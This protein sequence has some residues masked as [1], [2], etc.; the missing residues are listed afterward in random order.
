MTVLRADVLY[1]CGNSLNPLI[2][3]GQTEGAFV[4]GLGYVFREEV[5]ITNEGKNNSD[6]TWEYKPPMVEIF[7]LFSFSFFFFFLFFFFF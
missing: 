4:M 3:L 7:F 6:D 1:D 2:D 5:L